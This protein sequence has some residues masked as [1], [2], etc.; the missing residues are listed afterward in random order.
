MRFAI[1][2]S[3]IGVALIFVPVCLHAAEP[4]T[5]EVDGKWEAIRYNDKGTDDEE[6][7]KSKFVAI[8][9]EGHQTITKA[10]NPW[11]ERQYSVNPKAKP[12]QI[13]WSDP[14]D[15]KVTALGIY[16]VKDNMMTIA[17][18]ADDAKRVVDRPKDFKPSK[19]KTVVVYRLVKE[20]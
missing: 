15:G 4:R 7:V 10:G 19:D 5:T 11:K 9:E 12:K 17:A 18:Y 14:K 8:R 16:K 6:I 1:G 2:L 3:L 20:K 13:T